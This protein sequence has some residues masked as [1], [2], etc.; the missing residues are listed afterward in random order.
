MSSIVD[1]PCSLDDLLAGI[2]PAAQMPAVMKF[3]RQFHG[4]LKPTEARL[5]DQALLRLARVARLEVRTRLAHRLAPIPSGPMQTVS[6]LALDLEADVAAP[7]LRR[8]PLVSERDLITVA[9]TRSQGHLAAVAE[10]QDIRE[11]VTDPITRRGCW[12][13]LRLLAANQTARLSR[14]GRARLVALARGDGHIAVALSKREDIPSTQRTVLLCHFKAMAL[15]RPTSLLG[16]YS[17]IDL[18]RS[19]SQERL[20]ASVLPP[21]GPAILEPEPA[22]LSAKA[23]LFAE[24]R[25]A[26]LSASRP[27][28]GL[29]VTRHLAHGRLADAAVTI[30]RLAGEDPR[31]FVDGLVGGERTL[32]RSLLIM[33][34][35]SLSWNVV[36]EAVQAFS[37]GLA[38]DGV[39]RPEALVHHRATYEGMSTDAAKASLRA[40][41]RRASMRV[42]EGGRTKS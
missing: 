9:R 30:G 18:G 13:V 34:A 16:E 23:L 38:P 41:R 22:A 37:D 14:Y 42:I 8:S 5:Y 15:A 6:D 11:A 12:P 26:A 2:A 25:V 29:E 36:E 35:A 33:A 17:G 3:A 4:R 24:A 10:R 19:A 21:P 31:L 39:V 32:G 20:E 28:T 27:L 7:V 1:G 40:M